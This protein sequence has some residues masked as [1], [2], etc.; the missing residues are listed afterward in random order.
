MSNLY[1]N[2]EIFYNY[3]NRYEKT[4]V[5][6]SCAG[7]TQRMIYVAYVLLMYNM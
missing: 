2:L 1:L 6:I 4:R 7:A 3:V 5:K